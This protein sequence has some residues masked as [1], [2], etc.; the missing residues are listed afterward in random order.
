MPCAV[1]RPSRGRLHHIHALAIDKI[2]QSDGSLRIAQSAMVLLEINLIKTTEIAKAVG[3]VSG[4]VAPHAGTGAEFRIPNTTVEA[5]IFLSDE[6][7]VKINVV[8]DEDAVF[9]ESR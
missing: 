3:A 9:Q 2:E 6:A 7:I 8:R 5:L 4:I 1:R